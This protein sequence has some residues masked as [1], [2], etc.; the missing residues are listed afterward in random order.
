MERTMSHLLEAVAQ[1]DPQRSA[2]LAATDAVLYA[3][4]DLTA[5]DLAELDAAY[6]QKKVSGGL[7]A[8]DDAQAQAFDLAHLDAMRRAGW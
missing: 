7:R 1:L 5:E 3:P 4:G 8:R 2:D 6:H